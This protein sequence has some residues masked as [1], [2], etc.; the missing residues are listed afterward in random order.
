[1][2][3]TPAQRLIRRAAHWLGWAIAGLAL[4]V[5]LYLLAAWLGSSIP[6]NGDWREPT[7]GGVLIGVETNGVHT[8]LVLP[9][10]TPAKDWR[11][12]F[13]LSDVARPDRPYTHVSISW[14][15][16]A[17]FLDTPTWWDLKPSTVLRVLTR[18]G[19]GLAHIAFY[20][21]PAASEELRPIRLSANQY[22]RLVAS[23]EAQLPRS[24]PMRRHAGY[25]A[26]DVFYEVGGRYTAVNTCNQWTGNRLADAGVRIGRWTPLAS[27]VMKW[28]ARP[29]LPDALVADRAVSGTARARWP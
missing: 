24:R 23:I 17:V 14:G 6:R 11:R 10:V 28:A 22:A 5:V 26:S 18:G 3:A 4:A 8:A 20:A 27:G 9:L 29:A 25:G 19:D 12:D 7:S 21:R 1:M 15:E 13:P 16:R 2:A